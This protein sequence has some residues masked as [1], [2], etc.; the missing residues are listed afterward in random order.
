MP[1]TIRPFIKPPWYKSLWWSL[2]G[3][4]CAC[5]GAVPSGEIICVDHFRDS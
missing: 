4:C 2:L 5:G 3:R 1:L